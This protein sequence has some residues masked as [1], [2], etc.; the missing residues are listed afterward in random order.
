MYDM[1]LHILLKAVSSLQAQRKHLK[2]YVQ[3]ELLEQGKR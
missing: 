1:K 3:I 2:E